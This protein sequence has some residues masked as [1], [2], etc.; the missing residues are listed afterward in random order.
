[1]LLP[2]SMFLIHAWHRQ[3][4]SDDGFIIF[5]YAKNLATGLGLVWNAGEYVE[6]YTSPLWTWLI[7]L[8]IHLGLAP[9]IFSK[10]LGFFFG[11]LLLF[12]VFKQNLNKPLNAF[13]ICLLLAF[14]K[15]FCAWATSGL[16][17]MLFSLLVFIGSYFFLKKNKLTGT[18][19]AIAT[20][21]RPEGAIFA[22]V[23]G[24]FLLIEIIRKKSPAK[25][26]ISFVLQFFIIC[27]FFEAW[28]IWYYGEILPNTFYA[29]VS[30]LWF[31]Q[32]IKYFSLFLKDYQVIWYLPLLFFSIYLKPKA[33]NLYFFSLILTYLIYI[34][35]IGGD[36][37]EYRFLVPIM[38]YFY[39]LIIDGAEK[40]SLLVKNK[41]LS[42][43]ILLLI[44]S[45]I[46]Y[47]TIAVNFKNESKKV[48]FGIAS[49][50]GVKKYAEFR[51]KEGKFL[52]TLI[53]EKLIPK[54]LVISVGGAGA[55][56]Y[57][58]ELTTIDRRGLNDHYIARLPLNERGIIAHERDAPIDY[59]EKRNVVVFDILN[60]LIH[61][62]V[63]PKYL[64]KEE[65]FDGKKL[66]IRT[67]KAKDKYLTFA[68]LVGGKKIKKV[69]EKLE[70]INF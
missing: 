46:S 16:E 2:L 13:L 50:E 35:C 67:F 49:L 66:I 55:V 60:R 57:Y 34:F 28:R 59:L 17:T 70:P 42:Y 24:A 65:F 6:G 20:L 15:S 14:N 61:K 5:R 19:F 22:F 31:E 29:K 41:N 56:P 69:F 23:T 44:F 9:E 18:I 43:L 38:A 21:T 32:S 47:F 45:S 48:R 58:S 39:I 37:F 33:S 11:L 12:L 64:N 68:S 25:S 26:L 30:G 53:N 36:R 10:I 40:L 62:K 8:G 52:K 4:L 63:K 1:M 54:D 3:F 51:I 27:V 7:A